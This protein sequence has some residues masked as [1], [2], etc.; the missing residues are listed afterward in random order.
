MCCFSSIRKSKSHAKESREERSTVN[1]ST[2]RPLEKNR[3]ESDD[4]GN[5]QYLHLS[6]E[7]RDVTNDGWWCRSGERQVEHTDTSSFVSLESVHLVPVDLNRIQIA[8]RYIL[9]RRKDAS[10]FL[11]LTDEGTQPTRSKKH[12]QGLDHTR[13]ERKTYLERVCRWRFSLVQRDF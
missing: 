10:Q 2:T 6:F 12:Y 3:Y 8:W 9:D 7:T 1:I 11:P 5:K 4:G 13:P